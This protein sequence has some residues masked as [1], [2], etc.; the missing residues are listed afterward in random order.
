MGL[1]EEQM[2]ALA[3]RTYE[4][5][6]RGDLDAAV[7]VADPSI[8]LVRVGDQGVVRGSEA[9]R[10][11][12]E[13]D[14]FES[15]AFDPLEFRVAGERVLIRG[16]VSTRG[17]GSGIEMELEAW[18][19]WTFNEDGKVVRIENFLSHEEEAAVSALEGG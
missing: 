7:E 2:V 5:F 10:A 4:R 13:P 8:V 17:A 3:R 12:M 14:A 19:L 18:T 11:W 1:T 15:Q 9:V 16:R 6:N